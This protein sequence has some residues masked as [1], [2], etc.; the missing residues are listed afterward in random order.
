MPLIIQDRTFQA[1]GSFYYSPDGYYPNYDP[2]PFNYTKENPYSL[3]A[4]LGNTI[5]VN[6]K[7]WPNMN[8]S[9]GQYRFRLL[10]AS[11]TRFY[12]I[13]FSNGMPFTLIGSDGGYIK[14]AV[15]ITSKIFSPAERLDILV[16]FWNIAPGEKILLKN[17]ALFNLSSTKFPDQLETV[18]QIMQFTV[19]SDIG[20]ELQ[21]LPSPLN[22]TLAGDYPNLPTPTKTRILTLGEN[23]SV[24]PALPMDLY[25]D[26]QKWESP[27]SETP[28]MGSTEDWVLVNTFDTHN[29][30]L[31]LVQFQLVSRQNY[32]VTSY[33]NDWR[34]LNGEPPLNHTT[35]NLESLDPYLIG[36]PTLPD[37]TEQ[38]WKDTIIVY[39]RQ[40]TVIRIRFAQQ[41]GKDFPFDP[42][43]GPGYVWHCHILEH[44]DNAMMRPYV[45]TQTPATVTSQQL[46]IAIVALIGIIVVASIVIKMYR[47]RPIKKA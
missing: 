5:M 43:I 40:I 41:D 18:G 25:L 9:R 30:H 14:T 8:V 15:S 39:S 26:G 7:V 10:D 2:P 33:W 42:T 32:N 38:S 22:P 29:I 4:A 27:V 12:N 45:I 11:N 31:H 37:S 6:G 46:I 13:S 24:S 17:N 34:A 44:E 47:L 35:I 28:E 21:S 19:T 16:D 1:D 20:F 36:Q 3:G 23:I